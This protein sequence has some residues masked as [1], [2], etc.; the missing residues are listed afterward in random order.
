MLVSILRY[1]EGNAL[2]PVE[3]KTPHK[4][5][6]RYIFIHTYIILPP[7]PHA[8]QANVLFVFEYNY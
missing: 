7:T 2:I 8:P 1:L 6:R 4:T 5:T 3:H